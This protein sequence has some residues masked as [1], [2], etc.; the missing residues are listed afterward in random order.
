MTTGLLLGCLLGAA[1]FLLGYTLV[2]PRTAVA[3]QV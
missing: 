3:T 2:P 1:V